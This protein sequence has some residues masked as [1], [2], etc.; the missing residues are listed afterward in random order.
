MQA[1]LNGSGGKEKPPQLIS[2]L[3]T[4]IL[5]AL[6]YFVAGKLGLKLAFVNP[7]ATTVWPPT[8][9]ALAAFILLGDYVWPGILLGAFLVNATT[10]GSIPA[11][12]MIAIGNTLEGWAGAYLVRRFAHG[13][14]AFNLTQDV[15]RF[16]ILLILVSTPVSATVGT[17][18]LILNGLAGR[19]DFLPIWLTWW[20]GDIGGGLIVAPLLILW[21]ISPRTRWNA[22]RRTEA[23][24]LLLSLALLALLVFSNYFPFAVQKYPLEFIF[25]PLIVWAALRFGQREAATVTAVLSGIAITSTLRGM[26][27]FAR[28]LPNESLLL[29]QGFMDIVAITGLGLAALVAERRQI[30]AALRESNRKLK[31]SLDELEGHNRKMNLLNKMGDL[32]QSCSAIEEAYTVI[33]QLGQQLFAEK[34]GALYMINDTKNM[35][36]APVI[37]GALPPE[38]RE[39]GLDDCWALRRGRIHVL[40]KDGFELPCPH[41]KSHRPLASICIPVM[42]QSEVMGILH[43][44]NGEP[45]TETDEQ[46]AQAMADSTALALANLKLRV[47]LRQ[48]SIRDPLTDLFNRRYLEETFEREL[49][50]AARLG[51]PVGVIML[52]LD[53]FK[54]FNDKFGH[55][56]GDA[57]LREL[58]ELIKEQ[59]RSS[60]V[61]CRYGGEEFALILPE[62]PLESVRERAEQL[63]EDIK[64]LAVKHGGETLPATTLSLGIAMYPEHGTTG[65]AV[66]QAADAALYEAKRKGRDRV[67]VAPL[68]EEEPTAGQ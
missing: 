59:V 49:Y 58:S 16:A 15:F 21:T 44:Q 62:I 48:Q 42:A 27:P 32:L 36:E 5:L 47:S 13:S 10:S 61:A 7:S 38:A 66:L 65:K 30:E 26:G 9:I 17:T 55:A 60:D 20:L 39:F 37:W 24:F 12:L 56:A 57:L 8:G 41:L 22:A 1:A 28:A 14:Q 51:Q 40:N 25:M 46:L 34:G 54:N 18:S 35:A 11:S 52:D 33:G 50:R 45:F 31:I 2:R 43:L 23:V 6:V 3:A 64:H 29:L 68:A 53:H 63:R 19:A 67:T 4:V